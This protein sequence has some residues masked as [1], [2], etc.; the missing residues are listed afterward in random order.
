ML[1]TPRLKG[2]AGCEPADTLVVPAALQQQGPGV[3]RAKGEPIF[4]RKQA[5]EVVSETGNL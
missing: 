4:L 1:K 5:S 3:D 2:P